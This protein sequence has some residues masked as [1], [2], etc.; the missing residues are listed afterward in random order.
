M[1]TKIVDSPAGLQ[2]IQGKLA[3]RTTG[4]K[5]LLAVWAEKTTLRCC[6]GVLAMRARS[7]HSV[8][9]VFYV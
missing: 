7:V 8:S 9:P 4:G 6:K 1:L 2:Y 5:A 3:V